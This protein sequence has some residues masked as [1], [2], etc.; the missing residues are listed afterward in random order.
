MPRSPRRAI[1]GL[2]LVGIALC[3]VLQI[4]HWQLFHH[5]GG[6]RYCSVGETFDCRTVG[7]SRFAVVL[8]V[9]LPLWGLAAFVTVALAAARHSGWTGPL[10]FT[11]AALSLALLVE[12]VVNIGA[13]CLLCEGVHVLFIAI[14]VIAWLAGRREPSPPR[15]RRDAIVFAPGLALLVLAALAL[16]PYWAASRWLHEGA[17]LPH[18]EDAQ[19]HPWIGAQT[20]TVVLEEW[21]DYRCPHCAVASRRSA[22]WVSAEPERLRLV[23]RHQPGLRCAPLAA[24]ETL[25]LSVRA[26]ICA[27]KQGKFWEM[28]AWLFS[29]PRPRALTDLAPATRDLSL[30]TTAFDACLRDPATYA[31]AAAEFDAAASE[32]IRNTPSYRV[33]GTSVPRAELD[34]TIRARLAAPMAIPKEGR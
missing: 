33:D 17:T 7:L 26:A 6:G 28:D 23:R 16:P 11:G 10:A 13:I 27:G 12:E 20:P 22:S 8:G 3:I 29:T 19:G 15:A 2:A 9:P 34:A 24:S 1:V 21:V 5:S 4:T 18:G 32:G 25:C 31:V 14:A 30:D